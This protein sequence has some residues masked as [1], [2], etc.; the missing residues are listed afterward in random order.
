MARRW[1][2]RS[3][4][5]G[6]TSRPRSRRDRAPTTTC[7]TACAAALSEAD[8]TITG[9]AQSPDFQLTQP[10]LYVTVGSTANVYRTL[11][12]RGHRGAAGRPRRRRRASRTSFASRRRRGRRSRSSR[13]SGSRSRRCAE[14][15][16]VPGHRD[17]RRRRKPPGAGLRRRDPP[18]GRA[19]PVRRRLHL[20][21]PSRGP[22]DQLGLAAVVAA[23]MA[24]AEKP[25][26]PIGLT[27]V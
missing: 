16:G 8:L 17:A 2:S 10:G 1:R 23:R 20:A 3:C 18:P 19:D 12:T 21:R 14:D 22:A 25:K 4:S 13:R 11:G 27:E 6:P 15:G 24:K 7:R 5:S 9:E 26:G